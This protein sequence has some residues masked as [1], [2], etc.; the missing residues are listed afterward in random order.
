MER[1]VLNGLELSRKRLL[2][3]KMKRTILLLAML[4]RDNKPHVR[5][6]P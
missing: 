6:M 4:T 3:E 5:Y 1:M 2:N